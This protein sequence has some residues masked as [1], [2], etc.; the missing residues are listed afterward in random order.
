[1][2]DPT[3]GVFA[4]A[5]GDQPDGLLME[6]P[7][8]VP[9]RSL[10]DRW[11]HRDTLAAYL[12]LAPAL[13]HF[14]IFFLGL[15]VI[16]LGLS[17]TSWDLFSPPKFVGLANYRRLLF[18][19]PD[20]WPTFWRTAYYV[21]LVIPTA[22]AAELLLALAVNTRLR[23]IKF[24]R[25]TYFIPVVASAVAVALVWGWILNTQNGILN[26][27]L[28][29]FGLGPFD[30]L[31]SPRL[32]MPAVAMVQVWRGLGEGMIIFLAGLQAIPQ[33][34]YEA[35]ELDGA[36]R[37]AKFRN[38]TWPLLSP[39]TFFVTVL[40]VIGSFQVFD[41]IYLLTHGG[42]G[43]AT[44]V[45]N[46]ELY[47]QAFRDFRMG[48]AAAMTWILFVVIG[49]LTLIQFRFINKRVQYELG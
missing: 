40:E 22:V 19:D 8:A 7:P 29:F 13:V 27:F 4:P 20:F 21:V 48:Y 33:H 24:F 15:V 18:E 5:L 28:N 9:R 39:T 34:L 10:R 1:M 38:V 6:T 3:P 35:A 44:R 42:P 26:W 37:W 36:G 12:F 45:Y 14:V 46:Y 16:S 17:F 23:A 32:A 30:W 41:M 2:S 11:L 31:G 49:V 43:Q 47:T 25:A